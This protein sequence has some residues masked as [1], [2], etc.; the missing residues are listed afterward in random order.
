LLKRWITV[1]FVVTLFYG[2]VSS[3]AKAQTGSNCTVGHKYFFDEPQLP[4]SY[5][6]SPFPGTYAYVCL[7]NTNQC[8]PAAS[9][10]ETTCT[11]CNAAPGGGGAGGSGGAGGGGIPIAG[12]PISLSTGNTFINETDVALPGLAGGLTLR[13]TWN[14]M[15]PISQAA[16]Q[17]G[18]FG[19]NWRSTFEERIF[20][21]GDNYIKYSRSDGSFWSFGVNITSGSGWAVAAPANVAADLEQGLTCWTLTFQNGEQR[22]FDNTTGNLI[23]IVDRNG[24]TT[25]ISYDS[26]NRLTTVTDPASRHLTFTYG[27]PSSYL[28]TGVSSDVGLSL[29]YSYDNQG[30]LSTVT[31]PD[32]STVSFAYNTQSLITSVVDP[33][34]KVLESHTYDT[35]FRG[36]SSSQA[37]G[38]NALTVTYPQ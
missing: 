2:F 8:S 4:G 37:N 11:Q 33:N 3:D 23:A 17:L 10:S 26:S 20:V 6:C 1:L 35:N 30:R 5:N 32:L 29:T 9:S 18:I 21:G 22:R 28:V 36:L 16:L 14:S 34:G 12:R 15:W 25:Q 27:S 24:N 31:K 13:R 19:P 38:V 7:I